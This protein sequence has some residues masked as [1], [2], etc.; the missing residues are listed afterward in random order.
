MKTNFLLVRLL[1][2]T[3]LLPAWCKAQWVTA[4]TS[5]SRV[6]YQVTR[7]MQIAS[8]GT[9]WVNCL[10]PYGM[11]AYDS[12]LYTS[13][14]NGQTWSQGSMSAG[15]NPAT[16]TQGDA[17]DVWA[18]DANQAWAIVI[19]Y[20]TTQRQLQKT[21]TGPLGFG[22]ALTTPDP[23]RLRFVRFFSPTEGV[24]LAD[25]NTV[26]N[27]W[28]LYYT[29]DGGLTWTPKTVAAMGAATEVLGS[30][31]LA[32][33]SIW[34]VTSRGNVI[35]SHDRGQ[36]W[37][38]GS[39]G[40]TNTMRGVAFRDALHGLA[41]GSQAEMRRTTDGGATW[42][43]LVASGTIR[44][45][46]IAA[47]GSAGTYLSVGQY[48][49]IGTAIST[50]DGLSWRDVE[51]SFEHDGLAV[52]SSNQV[53]TTNITYSAQ[54]T[55]MYLSPTVL[56]TKTARLNATAYPNPTTGIVILSPTAYARQMVCYDALGKKVLWQI[57]P[58]GATNLDIA[59]CAS[60]VYQMQLTGGDA[61]PMYLRIVK[62]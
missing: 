22:P 62:E 31:E 7:N 26:T 50:D 39:T 54:A 60:G 32:G 14:N 28:G 12:K 30:C 53:W 2:I 57:L 11:G 47:V 52:G 38:A 43:P 21:T 33:N 61:N 51:S 29:A 24:A 3:L 4:T 27:N 37:A 35:F 46:R 16:T 9:I 8:D 5:P 41:Y 23:S 45:N 40:I 10:L 56:G 20:A 1:G 17:V 25:P 36:N 6:A 13:T 42:T 19:P 15:T 58:A 48:P 59:G 55:M 18:L 34:G 44:T 49:V